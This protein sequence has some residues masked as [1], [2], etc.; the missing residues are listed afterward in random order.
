MDESLPQGLFILGAFLLVF[1]NGFFVAAEFSIVKVRATRIDELVKKGAKRAKR[2]RQLIGNMD[3]TLSATQLGITLTSLGLGWIGEP[4]FAG[5][6]APMFDGMGIMEPILSHSLAASLAFAIITFLHIVMGELAPK[7][8]AIQLPERTALGISSPLHLFYRIS[9]PFIW[10]L[11]SAA[12]GLLRLVGIRPASDV[13]TAHSEEELRMILLQSRKTGILDLEEQR[14]LERVFD[15]ADRSARQVMVPAGEVVFL[16]TEKSL[17]ENLAVAE[18]HG[19]TRYPLCEG[20]LN[21]IIGIIH[22][23]DLLWRSKSL[24]PDFDLRAIK[25]PVGFFPES[26]LIK[27]LLPEFR[28]TQTHLAVLVDEFGS[29]IGIVT[30]EDILEE[31][32]GEIQDEFDEVAPP[33]MIRRETSGRLMVKGRAL[34]EDLEP[35]LG[36]AFDDDEN[37]TI[38][39]HVMMQLGRMAKVGDE[40]I[41]GNRYKVRVTGVRNLQITDLSIDRL[42]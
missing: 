4:A 29:S 23:K 1:L 7:S 14:M 9:Y 17:A 26:K 25:R 37:D 24:G 31:L 34:L 36:F 27:S 10:A 41:L 42:R 6:F 30:L 5:L 8:L 11:N 2:A 19:H 28:R 22:V 13:E 35:E 18:E 15:F 3:E 21:R 40:V 32:V 38:A 16:D 33:A 20:D 12:N 39:G